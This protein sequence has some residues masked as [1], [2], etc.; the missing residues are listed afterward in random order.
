MFTSAAVPL[1]TP[2]LNKYAFGTGIV[3]W[4]FLGSAIISFILG[5]LTNSLDLHPDILILLAGLLFGAGISSVQKTTEKSKDP[6][7]SIAFPSS[8]AFLTAMISFF[9]LGLSST[10]TMILFYILQFILCVVL[11]IVIYLK[12]SFENNFEWLIYTILATFC[13]SF[14]DVILKGSGSIN[15]IFND[16]FW[17]T[18]AGS[19]IPL[20]IN[21]NTTQSILPKFRKHENVDKKLWYSIFL[22]MILVFFLKIKSRTLSISLV[23]N[24]A[25]TQMIISL[26]LPLVALIFNRTSEQK[27]STEEYAVYLAMT[28]VTILSSIFSM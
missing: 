5:I 15:T 3:G 13:L 28:C 17:F 2:W 14:S 20:L 9:I 1:V 24:P 26:S 18:L 23:S 11:V 8:R 22:T 10:N 4:Y 19:I 6:A 27:I 12:H 7:L 21:F 16:T 25:Y